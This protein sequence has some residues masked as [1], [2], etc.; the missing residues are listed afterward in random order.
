SASQ[1][2]ELCKHAKNDPS[3]TQ[4]DLAKDFKIEEALALWFD[5]AIKHNLTIS[6]DILKTKA[7]A[8][9]KLININ[10]FKVTKQGESASAPLAL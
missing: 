9:A 3:L 8:L 4:D 7:Q 5:Q 2:K 6:V 1:K 10:N